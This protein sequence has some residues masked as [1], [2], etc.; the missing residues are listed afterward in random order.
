MF[1][2]KLV[3]MNISHTLCHAQYMIKATMVHQ[4]EE[5]IK[6]KKNLPSA[7]SH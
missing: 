5:T 6:L 2:G 1:I 3:S 4:M 7:F